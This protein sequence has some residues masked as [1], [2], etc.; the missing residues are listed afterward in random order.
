MAGEA[1]F[2]GQVDRSKSRAWALQIHY[3]WETGGQEGSL[4]DALEHTLRTRT[5]A[6]RRLPYVRRLLTTLDDHLRDLDGHLED[7]L[8]NWRLGRLA[9]IDR[10]VLRLGAAELLHLSDVPPKVSIHEAIRLAERYGTAESP[11][12]VN[13]V[14]DALYKRHDLLG[15]APTNSA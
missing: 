12:F 15:Q 1:G 7:A 9:S 5:I 3:L 13:G 14:L 11:R 6:E 2:R 10:G 4:L 8:D